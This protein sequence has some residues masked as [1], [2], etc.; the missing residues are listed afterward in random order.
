MGIGTNEYAQIIRNNFK[1][2]GEKYKAYVKKPIKFQK[3]VLTSDNDTFSSFKFSENTFK[4]DG[5]GRT[6]YSANLS[7]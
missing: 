3:P 4:L 1:Y 7:R 5:K 2:T 6:Q